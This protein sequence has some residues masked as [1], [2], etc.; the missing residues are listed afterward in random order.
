MKN[1]LFLIAALLLIS[2]NQK[3]KDFSTVK[4]GMT[5]EEVVNI[6]G[7]PS[8]KN[9]LG[10]Q[11]WVYPQADRT[12]VFRNDTVYDVITSANARLDSIKNSLEKTGENIQKG[13]KNMA[14]DMD[15]S[16]KSVKQKL[17]RDTL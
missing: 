14:E 11:L 2:C 7:E 5:K 3:Q 4:I 16:A 1:L 8:R 13:L 12:V 15:S 9:D 10:I 17:G 6:V